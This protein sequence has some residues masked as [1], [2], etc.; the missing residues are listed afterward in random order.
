MP[1]RR[2]GFQSVA[3]VY[4]FIVIYI[5]D[6]RKNHPALARLEP[7]LDYIFGLVCIVVAAICLCLAGVFLIIS[8]MSIVIGPEGPVFQLSVFP[9]MYF[10]GFGL[11]AVAI[12]VAIA[13]L[14]LKRLKRKQVTDS[15]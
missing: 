4:A 2:T 1:C 10:A 13:R 6:V 5:D 15:K 3:R 11:G 8:L 14:G 7:R 9:A 12:G